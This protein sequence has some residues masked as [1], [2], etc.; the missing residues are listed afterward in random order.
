MLNIQFNR[1]KEKPQSLTYCIFKENQV[2][3]CFTIQNPQSKIT[4]GVVM[5]VRVFQHKFKSLVQ[6]KERSTRSGFS[7]VFLNVDRGKMLHK[8]QNLYASGI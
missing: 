4:R 2:K 7:V 8:S 3:W 1:I 5:A 6:A